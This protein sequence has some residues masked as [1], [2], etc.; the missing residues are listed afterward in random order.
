M[1]RT[2]AFKLLSLL[3]CISLT[4]C[5]EQY[6]LQTDTYEDAL[7]VEATITNEVKT[8][9]IKISHTYSLEQNGPVSEE[10]AEVYVTDDDG[11]RYDFEED[12]GFYRSVAPFGAV[13]GKIYRLTIV[14]SQGKHYNSTPE[15]LTTI[16]EMQNVTASV[17][18]SNG[19]RGVSLNA[20]SFDP[21][22]S[23]KYYRYE[24]EETYKIVAPKW[25]P[26]RAITVPGTEGHDEIELIPRG[27]VETKTCYAT[28][29][30][31][32]I[33]LTSSIGKSEDRIDF[34]VRFISA[35][36]SIIAH[37]YSILVTQYIQNLAAYTFYKTLQELSGTGSILSQ[38]Q[39]GFFYGNVA[40]AENPNEKV[41]GF[42]EVASV[43]TKRIFF[44]YEDLFPGQQKPPYFVDC[45]DKKY[46]FCFSQA[47]PE[48]KGYEL[49]NMI[50]Q[51][52]LL[53]FNNFN[54]M[55]YMVVPPC[56]DCTTFASNIVPPFWE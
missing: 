49:L 52:E 53:Y 12:N 16:N 24:Y 2:I 48:C 10:G 39:P 18:T 34:P 1:K 26:S 45:T 13:S 30:S 21:A 51:N 40:S 20:S 35:K 50:D 15:K 43:S 11:V 7:V 27:P 5:T 33:I 42:F 14:T 56:G 22:N 31:N 38:N 25:D 28:V 46:K 19:V 8:Q 29:K 32:A 55:Y 6:V 47:D 44:N 41:I 36:N 4:G 3:V 23:S 37:R 17:K 9:K 54:D